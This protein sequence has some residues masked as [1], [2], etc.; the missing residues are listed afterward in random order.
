MWIWMYDL[1]VVTMWVKDTDMT[2]A[3][4][5]VDW[6]PRVLVLDVDADVLAQQELRHFHE[7]VRSRYVQLQQPSTTMHECV[8]VYDVMT[9]TEL[10][11]VAIVQV[12]Q[13]Q[14]NNKPEWLTEIMLSTTN[15]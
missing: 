1:K 5:G 14:T 8:R 3:G 2:P 6:L 13:K 9:K 10:F 7:T 15:Q 4:G 12:Q 11:A